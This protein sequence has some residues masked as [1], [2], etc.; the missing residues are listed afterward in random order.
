M[1]KAV[2]GLSAVLGPAFMP[3]SNSAN[4]LIEA[5]SRAFSLR[6]EPLRIYGSSRSRSPIKWG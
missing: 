2:Y 5:R 4:I 6:L 1:L 3:G